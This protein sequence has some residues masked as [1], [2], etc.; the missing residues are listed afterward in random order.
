[1]L[2]VAW[3]RA[4]PPQKEVGMRPVELEGTGANPHRGIG[5][6]SSPLP[7]QG[8]DFRPAAVASA[9]LCLQGEG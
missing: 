3:Q 8:C 1:M 7:T 2:R 5:I 6:S 9:Q 4:A